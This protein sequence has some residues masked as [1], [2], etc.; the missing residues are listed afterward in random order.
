MSIAI[1]Q[2]A[3]AIAAAL[4]DSL[5]E[6]A[7]IAGAV[8]VGL[9][10]LPKLGAATRYAIWLCALAALVLT[11]I[12]TVGLSERPSAPVTDLAA[13]SEQS[14]GPLMRVA[15]PRIDS[16]PTAAEPVAAAEPTPQ[17]ARKSPIPIPQSLALAAA[18]IWMLVACARGL[19]LLL[20]LRDLAAVRREAR[21][22]STAYD[23]P[24]FLSNRVH[25]PI[26][27]GFLRAAI[28]LPASLVEQLHADAVEAIVIHEVAH[29]R[30]GDVWT[31]GL[32]RVAQAFVALNPV[33]W[34]VM[35]RLAMER[36]IA[37]DDWVVAR[38]GSGDAFALTL[39]A[40]ASSAR[41]RVPLAAASVFGSRHSI[42]VR[43]ERLLDS[44]QRRLRLSPPALGGA[45]VLLALI[46]LVLQS[47]SP[48]LAY[49]PQPRVL[50]QGSAAP[51]VTSCPVPNRGIVMTYLLG[52]KRRTSRTPAD[53][54]EMRNASDMVARL[55]AP[56]VALFDLTVDGAGKP[57]KVVLVSPP[58]YP[59]MGEFV[60]RVYMASTYE[61]ALRNCVPVEATI[62]S[63][64]PTARRSELTTGSV[65]TPVYPIGWHDQHKLACKVPTVTRGR[66]RAGFVPPTPY[67]AMLPAFPDSMKNIPIG[68]TF[69]TSVRVHVTAD[70]A[71]TGAVLVSSS[72]KPALDNAAL[73]AARGAKY[74][75]TVNSCKPAPT[76]YVWNT[77]FENSTILT[78]LSDLASRPAR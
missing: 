58:R 10:C 77:T 5:W 40:I 78:I 9:R 32:A 17:A 48:V 27:I 14:S 11:P 50:A 70:G 12:L 37:C 19:L 41:G 57:R 67:T 59:G 13:T 53:N 1:A 33:A 31:N 68:S 54:Q 51:A 69:E 42:V 35:R 64:V 29:L 39:W 75:L 4:F 30:R 71:A 46:G 2:A 15:R 74:P 36:E 21:L 63:G 6:G 73:T 56:N 60:T 34:F 18:L 26:A 66:F 52:P 25:V 38:T 47:L 22:W 20:D 61:P 45:V 28:V 16:E 62:R 3:L 76:E 55:G 44:G 7:L 43:I 72:G 49:E 23:Y 24:V 65:I 8:W